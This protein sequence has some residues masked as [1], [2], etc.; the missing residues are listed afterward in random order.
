MDYTTGI[1]SPLPNSIQSSNSRSASASSSPTHSKSNSTTLGRNII[2]NGSV[3]NNLSPSSTTQSNNNFDNESSSGSG[4]VDD[5]ETSNQK[6]IINDKNIKNNLLLNSSNNELCQSS[7]F[8]DDDD[9]IQIQ[10]KSVVVDQCNDTSDNFY[11]NNSS[12]KLIN[13]EDDDDDEQDHERKPL[14]NGYTIPKHNNRMTCDPTISASV[15][16]LSTVSSN[17][18]DIIGSCSEV[19]TSETNEKDGKICD[20]T[21]TQPLLVQISHDDDDMSDMNERKIPK[22]IVK[23][24]SVNS[25]GGDQHQVLKQVVEQER[26]TLH[27]QFSQSEEPPGY[28]QGGTDEKHAQVPN[29]PTGSI[30]SR[31]SESSSSSSSSSEEDSQYSEAPDGG[32]GWV[33]VF[34]SFMINLIADGITFSFGVIFVEFLNYFEES[35]GK[36]AWIGSLFMA[37]P[38]LSGP[39]ASFLTDRYGC[40]KVT[41]AGSILA[42]LGFVLSSFADSMEV[43]FLTFGILSGFGLSL[44]YVAAVVIVAYYFDKRRSFATGLSVCGSGIGTFIFAPLIQILL[45]EYGWRGTTL[46]LAG[47]FLNMCVCGMLMKDLEWT[48]QRAKLK[49]RKKRGTAISADSF[50]VSNSTNT[51][52]TIGNLPNTIP[53]IKELDV[54]NMTPDDPRLFSSLITLPTYVRNGEKVRVLN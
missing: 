31:G 17:L 11:I 30:L 18:D 52:G 26:P 25:F 37:M 2:G 4:C 19:T 24:S 47:I 5:P 50:S 29:T 49:R 34:A 27:V 36:T 46:I 42:A 13:S 33:V 35:K 10:K 22:S 8:R 15:N 45:D 53:E 21:L 16:N 40:R 51:A 12:D 43:L 6:K 54:D 7:M 39:I 20:E 28:S 44:C 38:L 3:C 41:I 14:H 48:K 9:L 1:Q 23:S 32:W